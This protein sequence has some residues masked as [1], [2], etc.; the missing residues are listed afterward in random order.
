VQINQDD[1]VRLL[2][3]D[4]P[5]VEHHADD[6]E[7]SDDELLRPNMEEAIRNT[8]QVRCC[9]R[10]LAFG[11]VARQAATQRKQAVIETTSAYHMSCSS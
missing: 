11:P 3:E 6:D 4:V 2:L 9:H 7:C 8:Q 10:P 1:N 5:E